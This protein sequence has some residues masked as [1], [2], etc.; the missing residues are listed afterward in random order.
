MG[1]TGRLWNR[2]ARRVSTKRGMA[3]SKTLASP[4]ANRFFEP[5]GQNLGALRQRDEIY[6]V[7]AVAIFRFRWRGQAPTGLGLG[8]RPRDRARGLQ[9]RGLR[10]CDAAYRFDGRRGDERWV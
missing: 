10:I 9:F 2:F 1:R 8:F 5:V 7:D 3:R 4:D 6:R